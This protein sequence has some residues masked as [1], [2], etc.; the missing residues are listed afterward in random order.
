MLRTAN[1]NLRLNQWLFRHLVKQLMMSRHMA[2]LQS[3]AVFAAQKSCLFEQW[4]VCLGEGFHPQT[5][6]SI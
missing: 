5:K 1:G 2:G 4:Y 6:S 3:F